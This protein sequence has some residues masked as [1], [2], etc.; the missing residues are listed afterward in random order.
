MKLKIKQMG[1]LP[2]LDDS[3]DMPIPKSYIGIIPLN[4]KVRFKSDELKAI[5]KNF[6]S[7]LEKYSNKVNLIVARRSIYE[8]ALCIAFKNK[9]PVTHF[10]DLRGYWSVKFFKITEKFKKIC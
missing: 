5:N 4:F 10:K 9:Y 2:T 8:N 7:S 1:I 6:S 3:F